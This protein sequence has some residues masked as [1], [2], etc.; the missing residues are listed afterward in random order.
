MDEV[1]AIA[2]NREMFGS[3]GNLRVDARNTRL[4]VFLHHGHIYL[5]QKMFYFIKKI[6]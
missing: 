5:E 3:S 6:N 2:V 4:C 1:T